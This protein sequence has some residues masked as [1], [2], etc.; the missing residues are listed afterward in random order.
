MKFKV[1]KKV[2]LQRITSTPRGEVAACAGTVNKVVSA[3]D[4]NGMWFQ[5]KG[6]DMW[7][8]SHESR[9]W[10][11]VV[12]RMLGHRAQYYVVGED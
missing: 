12:Q 2:M 6:S 9:Q 4:D 8:S 5:F 3:I 10:G 7:Y 1:G 11:V